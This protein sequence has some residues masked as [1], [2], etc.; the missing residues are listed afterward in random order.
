LKAILLVDDVDDLR[1]LLRDYLASRGF[2]VLEASNGPQAI[3]TVLRT[4]QLI[5]VL[6]TDVEMP[7]MNGL[8]LANQ[9]RLLKPRIKTIYMSSG[10]TNDQW[11]N[12]SGIQDGSHFLQKPFALKEL[13]ALIR[14]VLA[15]PLFETRRPPI[16][17]S[18]GSL[19]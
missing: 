15:Q 18:E 9:I 7:G 19:T 10:F 13:D 17:D 14:R 8:E 2:L 16:G 4:R 12:Q 5:N 11:K 3:Y 1:F 6:V